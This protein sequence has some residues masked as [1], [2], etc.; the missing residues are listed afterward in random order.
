[1]GKEAFFLKEGYLYLLKKDKQRV[2]ILLI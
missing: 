1:M 2:L